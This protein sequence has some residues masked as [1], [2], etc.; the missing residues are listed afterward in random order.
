MH[1]DMSASIQEI[2]DSPALR[3]EIIE[4][5]AR[6]PGRRFPDEVWSKRMAHWWDANPAAAELPQ[7]GWVLRDAD[8][9]MQGFLAAIPMWYGINGVRTPAVVPSTWRVNEE[10]RPA[11]IPMLMKLLSL[12]RR[13]PLVDTSPNA[14]VREIF[15]RAGLR[16]QRTFQRHLFMCGSLLGDMAAKWGARPEGFPQ[17]ASGLRVVTDASEVKQCARPFM[18]QDRLEKWITPEYLRWHAGAPDG[19][20]RFAGVV[21]AAGTLTS[22]VLMAREHFLGR[23]SWLA[24]DWFTTRED[25]KAAELHALLGTLCRQPGLLGNCASG[26]LSVASF[27]G[28]DAWEDAPSLWCG[29]STARHYY[30]LPGAL[31]S[32]SKRCVL[33][34][35]DHG[36]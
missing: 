2:Q 35:G 31:S 14:R 3:Q 10:H 23:Q 25:D 4:Y 1:G 28:D 21:D 5:L 29:P 12:G 33:A 24:A 34:E 7:R 19:L 18:R 15:D 27:E 36:L 30:T 26:W 32:V 20:F 16:V 9:L 6:S 13:V 11:S 22:Y 8:G 17:L